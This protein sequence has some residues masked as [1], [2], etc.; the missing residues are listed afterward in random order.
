MRVATCDLAVSCVDEPRA[1]GL[2]AEKPRF[3]PGNRW[4]T[5]I[6][7]AAC[8]DLA[9]S[10]AFSA[11]LPDVADRVAPTFRRSSTQLT[12]AESAIATCQTLYF[13]VPRVTVFSLACIL[14]LATPATGW[15]FAPRS[16]FVS[17]P[18]GSVTRAVEWVAAVLAHAPGTT[19]EATTR[20]ASWTPDDV[21]NVRVEIEAIRRLMRDPDTKVFPL[22]MEFDRG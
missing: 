10:R 19:D 7:R 3:R 11:F 1:G 20:T 12:Q 17:R 16:D 4:P 5:F 2:D 9:R 13:D 14:T 15:Q 21:A 6:F 8:G 18:Q 22:P